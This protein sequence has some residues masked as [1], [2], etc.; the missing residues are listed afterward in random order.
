MKKNQIGFLLF[1]IC[2]LF[3]NSLSAQNPH[4]SISDGSNSFSTI[5]GNPISL[6]LIL[7]GAIS[8]NVVVNVT[9]SV[10]TAGTSDFTALSTTVTIPAGQTTSS[11]FSIATTNDALVEQSENFTINVTAVSG[12]TSNVSNQA[13]ITIVDNDVTPTVT[14]STQTTATEGGFSASVYY[15]LSHVYNADVIINCVTVIGTAGASDFTTVNSS[16]T[17]PAGQTIVTKSISITNDALI[18]PDETFVL[19]GTVISGNTTNSALT[20]TIT[21][22]DNDTTPTLIAYNDQTTEGQTATVFAGL[23]RVYNSNVVVNFITT[24]GTAALYT[25]DKL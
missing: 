21:I 18:E 7:S 23:N 12:N 8:T 2:G 9:T 4:L 16:V 20:S 22:I 14:A 6:R 5:E 13:T 15:S 17:I 11:Y 24:T 1:L 3:F 10:G 19:N 25:W